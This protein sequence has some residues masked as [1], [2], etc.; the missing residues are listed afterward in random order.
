MNVSVRFEHR[1]SEGCFTMC[2]AMGGRR[3]PQGAFENYLS[4]ESST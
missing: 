4:L 2:N 1:H 3:E